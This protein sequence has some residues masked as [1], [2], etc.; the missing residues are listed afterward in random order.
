MD[1]RVET[2]R[3]LP[4]RRFHELL[5]QRVP[6]HRTPSRPRFPADRIATTPA[7]AEWTLVLVPPS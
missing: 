3:E 6:M 5:E 2:G 7:R 4:D 1:N